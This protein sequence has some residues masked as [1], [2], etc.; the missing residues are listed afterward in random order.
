VKFDLLAGFTINITLVLV[1][2]LCSLVEIYHIPKENN[3]NG[4]YGLYCNA[5]YPSK[6]INNN[7][8]NNN[9]LEALQVRL[10]GLVVRVP[11]CKF[12]GSGF[13]SWHYQIF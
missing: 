3:F 8:N 2:T 11:G 10:C 4:E 13:D 7:N 1:V 6:C 9:N 5:M 12:R